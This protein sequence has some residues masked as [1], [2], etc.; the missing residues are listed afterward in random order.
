MGGEYDGAYEEPE[1]IAQEIPIANADESP[2]SPENF[3]STRR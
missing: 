3:A 2:G 1:E